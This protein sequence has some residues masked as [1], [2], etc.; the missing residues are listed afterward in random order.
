MMFLKFM[1]VNN[2]P[3]GL[4]PAYLSFGKFQGIEVLFTS[5]KGKGEKNSA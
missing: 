5:K 1:K 4:A 3:T 2:N